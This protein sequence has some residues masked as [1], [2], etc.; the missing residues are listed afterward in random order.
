M[1][2]HCPDYRLRARAPSKRI[3]ARVSLPLC[4]PWAP[5]AAKVAAEVLLL[6]PPGCT[7]EEKSGQ[8]QKGNTNSSHYHTLQKMNVPGF[9]APFTALMITMALPVKLPIR[10]IKP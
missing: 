1:E 5:R 6:G 9:M 10:A 2:A 7:R 8:S 3:C 4:W